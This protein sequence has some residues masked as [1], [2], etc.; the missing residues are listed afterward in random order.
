M[1]LSFIDWLII[2]IVL[3]GMIYSV[4]FTK[5]LMRSVTDFLSAGRTAGRYLISVSQ[6]AAGLGAITI[7]SFLE[8]GYITGFSFQ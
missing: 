1:N 8:V 5:G 7:I 6:G 3:S 4:S 2:I